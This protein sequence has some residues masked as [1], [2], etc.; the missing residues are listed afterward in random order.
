MPLLTLNAADDPIIHVDTTPCQSGVVGA[1][2]NLICLVTLTGGHVGWP[3]TFEPWK[4]KFLFQNSLIL[5]YCQ[6]IVDVKNKSK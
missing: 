1:V 6:A 5:E 3:V 2:D 4:H